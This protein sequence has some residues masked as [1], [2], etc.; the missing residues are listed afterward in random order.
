MTV[1]SNL[2]SITHVILCVDIGRAMGADMRVKRL[3]LGVTVAGSA[4]LLAACGGGAVA[5]QNKATNP[6]SPAPTTTTVDPTTTTPP[7]PETTT[8]TS[9]TTPKP[10]TSKPKPKPAPPPSDG[11]TPCTIT[12][13]ACIDLSANKSWLLSGGKVSYGPVSITS[14]RPGFRTPPGLFHVTFKDIDHK[15]RE[16]NNAP[17][18]Y[19]VFF[20][21][22]MAFHSGSLSVQSHGCIHLSTA[23]AKMYYNSLAVG[24]AVQ[25][26]P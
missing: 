1:K 16:F 2:H 12:D 19:S 18:P 11:A 8:T 10:T 14:G 17:M 9:K 26:V 3:I 22:G 15:S 24:A 20:H 4:V 7:A 5:S 6:P 25:V 23:A 13:G 21:G